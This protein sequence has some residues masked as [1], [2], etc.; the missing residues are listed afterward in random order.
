MHTT[1]YILLTIINPAIRRLLILY[2]GLK[3]IRHSLNLELD[4]LSKLIYL[5]D[6]IT[7]MFVGPIAVQILQRYHRKKIEVEQIKQQN[8]IPIQITLSVLFYCS[9]SLVNGY[10][11]LFILM[12]GYICAT[13]C[14]LIL[15]YLKSELFY[16]RQG[17]TFFGFFIY[18]VFLV[19]VSGELHL[20]SAEQLFL[21]IVLPR[22]A[23]SNIFS[24]VR[25]RV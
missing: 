6:E 7:L 4:A 2:I 12:V 16:L 19:I 3:A 14:Y 1:L 25:K 23:Y 10:L 15:K 22:V 13:L 20:A 21:M 11:N 18:M 9:I 17:P 8:I 24:L 5:S